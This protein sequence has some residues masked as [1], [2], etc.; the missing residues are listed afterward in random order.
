M[1]HSQRPKY[2]LWQNTG[3][4]V[5]TAWKIHKPVVLLCIL[6]ALLAVGKTTAEMLIAPVILAKVEQAAP[7]PELVRTIL[8]FAVLLILLWGL[9]GY[10]D[11]NK[12]PGRIE[13]AGNFA[14]MPPK[15]IKNSDSRYNK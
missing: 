2:N 8:A 12:E 9:G 1:K 6:A 4:M 15:S 10:M 11:Q 7:L 5:S 13:V 3:Y 14:Q